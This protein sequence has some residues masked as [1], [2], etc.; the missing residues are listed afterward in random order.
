MVR[1]FLLKKRADKLL[2]F[3][4]VYFD[5][6]LAYFFL[7]FHVEKAC[8]M[9]GKRHITASGHTR[10]SLGHSSEWTSAKGCKARRCANTAAFKSCQ[11]QLEMH[12]EHAPIK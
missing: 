10:V 1:V 2:E 12:A 6:C 9:K 8:S 11:K 5:P 3:I 4:C 7:R